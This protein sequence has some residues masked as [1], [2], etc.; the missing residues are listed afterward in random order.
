MTSGMIMACS[1]VLSLCCLASTKSNLGSK[2]RLICVV[3]SSILLVLNSMALG[4]I[5][6]PSGAGAEV[7][8]IFLVSWMTWIIGIVLWKGCIIESVLTSHEEEHRAAHVGSFRNLGITSKK[9]TRKR[10]RRRRSKRFNDVSSRSEATYNCTDEEGTTSDEDMEE[11]DIDSSD[12]GASGGTITHSEFNHCL[13]SI[14]KN[15]DD[16]DDRR[17]RPLDPDGLL[18]RFHVSKTAD[19]H[20]FGSR[21]EQEDPEGVQKEEPDHLQQ[22]NLNGR[23]ATP[24]DAT[25]Y[26]E[27]T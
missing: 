26:Y 10:Q 2:E 12:D 5:S 7:G 4:V 3:S 24:R 27:T 15:T 17:R 8:S 6:S 11:G 22:E 1:A 9:K 20:N 23:Y 19:D 14:S 13:E 21:R 18:N 25:E 16:A